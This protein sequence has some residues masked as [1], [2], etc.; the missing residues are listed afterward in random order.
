MKKLVFL[1]LVVFVNLNVIAQKEIKEGK[2]TF[3]YSMTSEDPTMKSLLATM[4]DMTME[5][6]FKGNKSRIKMSNQMIG[7]NETIVDMDIKKGVL[8]MDNPMI[9][10]KFRQ[11]NFENAKTNDSIKVEKL[12]IPKTILGYKCNAYKVENNVNGVK[13]SSTLY[14]TEKLKVVMDKSQFG[15]DVKGYPLYMEVEVENMGMKMKVISEAVSIDE[16]KI[17]NELFKLDIPEGYSKIE[18]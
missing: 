6:Y 11:M 5:T 7:T 3:K 2:I 17:S 13:T 12:N 14:T 4:K 15:N 18:E 1:A 16:T 10:K 9:G 8:L